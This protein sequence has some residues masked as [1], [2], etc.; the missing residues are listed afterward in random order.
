VESIK[1]SEAEKLNNKQNSIDTLEEE[2][3]ALKSTCAFC[4]VEN[5]TGE[6]PRRYHVPCFKA[7]VGIGT[8]Y[9]IGKSTNNTQCNNRAS[10]TNN[11]YNIQ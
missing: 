10:I 7:I 5:P 9:V 8:D 3:N 11:V 6:C 1:A 2:I 4:N